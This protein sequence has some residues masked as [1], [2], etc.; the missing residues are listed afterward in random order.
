MAGTARLT[1]GASRPFVAKGGISMRYR[2]QAALLVLG[3]VLAAAF[4]A[5][6]PWD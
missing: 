3:S 6:A 1:D 2:I 4:V 5:G